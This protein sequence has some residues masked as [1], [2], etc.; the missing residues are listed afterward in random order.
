MESHDYNLVVFFN[1][2]G[3]R[4]FCQEIF[5]VERFPS[6]RLFP[7]NTFNSTLPEFADF[8]KFQEFNTTTNN[9]FLEDFDK[10]FLPKT[11]IQNSTE[12][13]FRFNLGDSRDQ[14]KMILISFQNKQYQDVSELL[15]YFYLGG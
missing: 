13:N 7:E 9:T 4:S 2:K 8:S 14:R 11:R 15:S 10:Y 3:E 1:C 6:L 12:F 5:G